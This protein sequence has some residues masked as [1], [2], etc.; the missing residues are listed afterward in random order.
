MIVHAIYELTDVIQTETD[1]ISGRIQLNMGSNMGSKYGESGIILGLKR[2]H[3]FM[4][5]T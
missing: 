1:R 5:F 4:F 2:S 3:P